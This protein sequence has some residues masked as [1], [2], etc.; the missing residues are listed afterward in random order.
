MMKK[1][2]VCITL[3]LLA[4]SPRAA[5]QIGF[6]MDMGVGARA[7]SMAGNHVAVAKDLS[8]AYWNPAALAYLP[9][10]EVQVTFDGMRTFGTCE[11]TGHQV[12]PGPR[13]D[14]YRN[15]LRFSGAGAMTAI[16]TLQGGLTIAA[17]YESP[18]TFDDFSV[19][20]YTIGDMLAEENIV[21]FGNLNRL[22]VAFGVQVTPNAS[23]GLALSVVTGSSQTVYDQKQNGAP[24][25]DMQ[26]DHSYLGY[27]FTAGALYRPTE[28]LKLGM[29]FNTLMSLGVK[30]TWTSKYWDGAPMF[31]GNGRPERFG[32][33]SGRAYVAPQGTVGAGLTLPWLTAALDVRAT[34]PY[35]FVLPGE[36][37]SEDLQARYFKMGAGLGLEA[38]VPSTSVV[39][40]AGYSFDECDLFMLVHQMGDKDIGYEDIDW[41]DGRGF[42]VVRNKHT[43]ALGTGIFT[44]GVGL[45]LSYSWQTWGISHYQ[46]LYDGDDNRI[47]ARRLKQMYSNHRLM[48]AVIFRY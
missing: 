41:D 32:P 18:K 47:G 13:N 10:R 9:V 3:S 33:L 42:D 4:I 11:V 48:A 36:N 30:E 19:Y 29:R 25:N 20:S 34:L 21:K 17:A 28:Y 23:A 31:Q 38:P 14:D 45:E 7:L 22:S 26:I 1:T 12:T 27:S 43:L 35:T 2:V 8:A 40:R 39:L 16:P 24:Y 44:A 37:I 6:G 46:A 15:R 5:A